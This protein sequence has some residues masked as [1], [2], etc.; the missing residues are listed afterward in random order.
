VTSAIRLEDDQLEALAELVASRLT[1][2]LAAVFVDAGAVARHLGV[3][4][5]YVYDHAVEFG[6]VKLGEGPR[7]RLRFRL[8]DVDRAVSCFTGR[9]SDEAES[10][11][12]KPKATRRRRRSL[13]TSVELLP[14]RGMK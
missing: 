13:G 11:V 12:V 8:E 1:G 14:I 10:G 6:G 3:E 4:R 5:S 2:S 9:G 7:A